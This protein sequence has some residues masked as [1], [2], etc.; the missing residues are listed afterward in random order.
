MLFLLSKK[1]NL[2]HFGVLGVSHNEMIEIEDKY[3]IE[4]KGFDKN[5]VSKKT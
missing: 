5:M 4:S 3:K 1:F 2:L